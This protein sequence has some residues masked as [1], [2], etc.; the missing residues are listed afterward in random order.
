M[1]N[2]SGSLLVGMGQVR[3]LLGVSLVLLFLQAQAYGCGYL[4]ATQ[5]ADQFDVTR[6][7]SLAVAIAMSY[8]IVL[9]LVSVPYIVIC[10]R[11]VQLH[12][13]ALLFQ[14]ARLLCR[15]LLMGAAVWFIRNQLVQYEWHLILRLLTGIAAGAVLYTLLAWNDIKVN[16]LQFMR[17]RE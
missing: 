16:V 10:F 8:S 13:R 14:F 9:L 12:S 5:F 15:A 17:Q 3:R 11:S 1:I 4:L 7:Q 2:I 6:E